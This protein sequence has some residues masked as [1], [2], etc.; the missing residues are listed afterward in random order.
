MKNNGVISVVIP[1]YGVEKYLEECIESI[2]NQTYTKLEVILVDDGSPDRCGHI[3]DRYAQRDS[4]IIV[5]HQKNGG[6]AAARNAGLRIATGEF[7][8]FVDGDDYLE[9]DAYEKMVAALLENDADIVHGGF[10]YVYVNRT[11]IH[12]SS[13]EIITFSAAQYLI[14]FTKDWTCTLSTIKLF[15]H[16]MLSNVFYEE[17]HLIDDEFFTYQ[18]VMNARKIVCIPTVV[19]NYRQRASSVMK[20]RSTIQRRCEDIFAFLE[21]RRKDISDRFPEL[22]FV[23]D[24]H[25]ADYL[26]YLPES[27]LGTE[28][29]VKEIKKRLIRHVA[30]GKLLLWKKGQRKLTL[31]VLSFLAMPTRIR[32]RGKDGAKDN[33]YEFFK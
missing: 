22:T 8:A 24:N 33:G 11:E 28:K 20:D 26:L 29:T 7:I 21:K 27:E 25:Y 17:G 30:D 18:G 13:D 6:A 9:P 12:N 3:C 14:H 10:N 19:Y 5:I 16:H 15:R 4:R 1:I 2:I 31:R 32:K 23:Y